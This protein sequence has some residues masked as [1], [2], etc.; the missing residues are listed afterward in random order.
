MRLFLTPHKKKNTY[1]ASFA[2]GILQEPTVVWGTSALGT[3]GFR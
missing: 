2:W 1:Q 3:Y